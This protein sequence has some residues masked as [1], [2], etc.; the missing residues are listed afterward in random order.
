MDALGDVTITL[1]VLCPRE[2]ASTLP[3]DRE[4]WRSSFLLDK[5]TRTRFFMLQR[6]N[7]RRGLD[8][9]LLVK[10]ILLREAFSVIADR[11]ANPY[12]TLHRQSIDSI[13]MDSALHLQNVLRSEQY[14]H[15]QKMPVEMTCEAFMWRRDN[16]KLLREVAI[17][18]SMEYPGNS[19]VGSAAQDNGSRE[20]G[21]AGDCCAICLEDMNLCE[22]EVACT[23]CKHEFHE[24]CLARWL[25][26]SNLCPLCRFAIPARLSDVD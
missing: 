10:E 6:G 4:S 11:T 20:D 18:G 3:E 22:V 1:R 24:D 9:L 14:S 16:L 2:D 8:D 15:L 19:R 26:I 12:M 23:P 21:G 5:F 17:Q 13:F 25:K 7:F